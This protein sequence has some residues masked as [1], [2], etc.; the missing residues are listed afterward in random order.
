VEIALVE[1][2][3]LTDEVV[4]LD[5]YHNL[6][7]RAYGN[8]RIRLNPEAD[9]LPNADVRAEL[10][11]AF[12]NG[13]EVSGSFWRLALDSDD[14]T[15][16]GAGLAKYHGHWYL[17]Q[18]SNVSWLSGEAAFSLSFAARRLLNPPREFVEL[19]GGIGEEAVVLGPGPTLDV[20]ETRFVRASIQRFFSTR[21]GYSAAAMYNLFEGTPERWGLMLGLLTRF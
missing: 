11:Q 6:W 2:F 12:E 9:V 15:V 17:R 19:S 14:V 21:W 5:A 1:R 20:R 7:T 3:D 8:L 13:W 16:L 4:A 18:V 10:F